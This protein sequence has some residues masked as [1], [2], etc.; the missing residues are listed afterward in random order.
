MSRAA[1]VSESKDTRQHWSSC[2]L[3]EVELLGGEPRD[4]AVKGN[5]RHNYI[6][7]SCTGIRIYFSFT[8]TTSPYHSQRL[9]H[10]GGTRVKVSAKRQGQCSS[11]R[12]AQRGSVQGTRLFRR[13][14]SRSKPSCCKLLS[15]R[16]QRGTLD[17]DTPHL[18][19]LCPLP[20][21]GKQ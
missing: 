11:K 18:I 4:Q 17:T 15:L 21:V 20:T 16:P 2:A 14:H 6:Y 9:H 19:L 1:P 7:P 10:Y 5:S 8:P 3:D 12:E 13:E